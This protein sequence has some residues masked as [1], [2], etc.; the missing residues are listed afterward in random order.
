MIRLASLVTEISVVD[1]EISAT[2]KEIFPYEHS[3]PVTAM[4]IFLRKQLRFLN[5]GRSK[6]R[7]NFT[8]YVFPL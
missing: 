5:C 4:N 8:L 3:N 6:L 7:H 1:T 2:R